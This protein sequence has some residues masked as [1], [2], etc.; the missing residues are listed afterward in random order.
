MREGITFVCGVIVY[1][2]IKELL[3][4]IAV[5]GNFHDLA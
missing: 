1:E 5:I 2:L 4:K 3:K